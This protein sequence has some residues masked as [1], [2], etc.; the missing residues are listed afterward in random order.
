MVYLETL[1][2]DVVERVGGNIDDS[3]DGSGGNMDDCE[4]R[5]KQIKPI[6]ERSTTMCYTT[7]L[8]HCKANGL[9]PK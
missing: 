4:R 3:S 8:E 9:P 6:K 5:E 7:A 1:T 2:S